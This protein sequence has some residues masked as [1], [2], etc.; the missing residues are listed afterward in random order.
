MRWGSM[1]RRLISFHRH[2]GGAK[3]LSY[4]PNS[5]PKAPGGGPSVILN[6]SKETA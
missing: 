6:K 3:D 5:G 1:S 2:V 4:L